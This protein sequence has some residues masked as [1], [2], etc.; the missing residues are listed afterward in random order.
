M[1]SS[2]W[3]IVVIVT[4]VGYSRRTLA[5]EALNHFDIKVAEHAFV[6]IH[7]YYGLQFLRRLQQ[8]QVDQNEPVFVIADRALCSRANNSNARRSLL[9]SNVMKMWRKSMLTWIESCIFMEIS[10]L[11]HERDRILLEI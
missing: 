5:E 1:V 3:K 8:F 11:S 2:D 7:D 4:I 10:D 6:K 9:F